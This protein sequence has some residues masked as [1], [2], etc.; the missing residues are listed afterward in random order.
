ME[1]ISELNLRESNMVR[2][3]SSFMT[4]K[5]EPFYHHTVRWSRVKSLLFLLVYNEN[6]NERL[7]QQ[8]Y[9]VSTSPAGSR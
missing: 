8:R 7:S 2:C 4:S 9:V 6:A 5:N 3:F 1:K